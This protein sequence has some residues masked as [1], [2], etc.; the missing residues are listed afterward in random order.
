MERLSMPCGSV[1][2]VPIR[3]HFMLPLVAGLAAFSAAAS[4][5]GLLAVLFAIVAVLVHEMGH[6]TAARRC[7]FAPDHI[8][9]WPLG[10][11]A[12]ISKQGITPREQIFVSGMGPATHVP[13]L[14]LW[15]GILAATNGGHVTLSTA[16][17]W[18]STHFVPVMCVAMLM[19]NLAMLAFNLL[20]PCIPLDC[21][22]IF[23]SLLLLC[24]C[25]AGLAA[26]IMVIVS[27]PI[28]LLLLL[29]GIWAW[30][31]GTS[32]ASLTVMMAIWLG[33]QTWKL[34]QARMQGQL[35]HMPLFASAMAM[36]TD[37]SSSSGAA[38]AVDPGALAGV[39]EASGLLKEQATPWAAPWGSQPMRSASPPWS[40]SP[41]GV[42]PAR[43]DVAWQSGAA[44]G[45]Q[46]TSLCT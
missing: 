45:E 41:A 29:F 34:H 36:K 20:V 2:G 32:M 1:A 21:S 44:R 31:G 10:G 16:G 40:L 39:A 27:V 28:V 43:H 26:K 13:M 7:G 19:N 33:V 22:Q 5:F 4:G 46:P 12:Y 30:M 38:A 6:V 17:M 25:E 11:L 42:A 23:V 8:L 3:V 9:L 35:A 18:Y 37:G 15:A 14:A 24:G